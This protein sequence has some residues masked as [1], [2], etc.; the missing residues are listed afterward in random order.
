MGVAQVR[1]A[2]A[3]AILAAVSVLAAA[4]K[5]KGSLDQADYIAA[6]VAALVAGVGVYFIPNAPAAPATA[7]S[8]KA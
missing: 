2:V 4:A 5:A 7:P 6:A 1:K 8:P 3:A